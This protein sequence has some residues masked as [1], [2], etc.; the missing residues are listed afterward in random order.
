MNPGHSFTKTERISIQKEIDLLFA[1]GASFPV[2]PLRI[3]YLEKKPVSGVPVSIL[4]SVPK[5]RFKRAVKRNRVK[6]WIRESYRLN[7]DAL[8]ESLAAADKGLLIA[9]VYVGKELY[10]F[11]TMETAMKKALHKIA[12]KP[13][14]GGLE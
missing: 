5:K 2:Y 8:C 13:P 6:R 9:F 7:K 1:E 14:Q 10:D 11:A 4:V 12:P 3:I